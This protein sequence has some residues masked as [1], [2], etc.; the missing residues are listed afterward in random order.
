MN[1][2]VPNKY[3][4]RMKGHK[5]AP[6]SLFNTAVAKKL[7]IL[8]RVYGRFQ[9]F[10]I[11]LPSIEFFFKFFL[12]WHTH[13]LSKDGKLCIIGNFIKTTFDWLLAEKGAATE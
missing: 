8:L 5:I 3:F 7:F 4:S 10:L 2:G 6:K 1:I 13:A 11:V 9:F 12:K